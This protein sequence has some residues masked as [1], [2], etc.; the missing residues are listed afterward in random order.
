M[1]N[2]SA[3]NP[4]KTEWEGLK[5]PYGR[6]RE[7]RHLHRAEEN[8]ARLEE[9]VNVL[10]GDGRSE[11][12]ITAYRFAVKDF[13]DFM[14]GLEV[15]E[16]SHRE[17]REWL[18]WL[19]AQGCGASTIATRKYAL[20]SFFNFLRDFRGAKNSPTRNIPNRR[21]TKRLP[22]W[23]SVEKTQ[24]LL[25][26]T[27]NPRDRAMVEFMWSTGC[28]PCEIC[29]A[30]VE[31][32]SWDERTIKV[33]GKGQ[34]ERL[35][36]LGR[37]AINSLQ[38]YLRV[39]PHIGKTGFLFR[40]N[41]PAQQGGIQL[42]NGRNWIAFWREN[43]TL[44][45][46]T[47]KRVLRGKSIGTI[48]NRQR[49]GPRPNATITQAAA[50]R[51]AGRTWPEI[52]A[53]VSPDAEMSR[54][55]QQRLQAA[56]YYRL[57]DSKHSPLKPSE[58]ITTYDEA[59]AKA[60]E[61]ISRVRDDSPRQLAHAVDLEAPL[62]TRS[63][64]RFVKDLGVKAG[65]GNIFPYMLR[66]SYA[67]HLLEGGADLRAIQSLLGHEDISTTAIYTHCDMTHLR[68]QVEKA[69]PN[70]QEERDEK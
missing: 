17:V 66:H 1:P 3:L 6:L 9:F 60:Q 8:S 27:D 18:H 56:V 14:C 52:F 2:L 34:K 37:N 64:G 53:T 33:L 49:T 58:Q 35:L 21:V 32:I 42:Q 10:R 70:C 40:R 47:V 13:L 41:L 31:N 38:A 23:L 15:T 22:Q 36:P 28:R 26:A 50:L 67:T 43:R 51:R 39:S 46:G 61:L 30:R 57:D 45:G 44:P 69:H 65:L 5:M 48:G 62:D 63:I 68:K 7:V 25:S 4:N 54:E 19:D 55:A 11:H 29:S 24:K 59:R 20:S 12:T 16:V